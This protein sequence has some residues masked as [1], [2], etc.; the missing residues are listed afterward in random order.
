MMQSYNITLVDRTGRQEV[1][2]ATGNT[3]RI[4]ISAAI[5]NAGEVRAQGGLGMM[6]PIRVERIDPIDL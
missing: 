5:L 6:A 3:L 2:E 1:S 4:A